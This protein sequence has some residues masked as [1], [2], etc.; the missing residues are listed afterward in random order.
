MT[1]LKNST[2][3]GNHIKMVSRDNAQINESK[4]SKDSNQLFHTEL[5]SI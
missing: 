5:Y 3:V 2:N 4:N 1:R